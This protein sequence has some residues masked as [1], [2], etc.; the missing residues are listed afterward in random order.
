MKRGD[1]SVVQLFSVL[2]SFLLTPSLFRSS[3]FHMPSPNF[4]VNLSLAYDNTTYKLF[5]KCEVAL[6]TFMGVES[7]WPIAIP[8]YG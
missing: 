7:F 4:S 1:S 8:F 5:A 2:S 3:T 6:H